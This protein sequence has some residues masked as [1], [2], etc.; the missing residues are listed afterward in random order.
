MVPK[1]KYILK[2]DRTKII[3]SIGVVYIGTV[4]I[5]DPQYF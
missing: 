4:D 2:T 3:K 5:I 1:G